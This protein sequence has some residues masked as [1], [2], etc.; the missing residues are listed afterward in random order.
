M[1]QVADLTR[2]WHYR[3]VLRPLIVALAASGLLSCAHQPPPPKPVAAVP[4]APPPPPPPRPVYRPVPRPQEKPEPPP[5]LPPPAGLVGLEERDAVRFFGNAAERS[6]EPPATVWRYRTENCE[7]DLYFYLDLKSGRMRALRYA[8]SGDAIDV[9][10]QEDCL[11][12]IAEKRNLSAITPANATS[13][14][15]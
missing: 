8:F 14:S 11:R 5:R 7:L 1:A 6:E 9:T 12:A 15:R 13:S 2:V 3:A 10:S 4:E